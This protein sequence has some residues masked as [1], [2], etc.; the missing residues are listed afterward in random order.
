MWYRWSQKHQGELVEIENK[1]L[2]RERKKG[3]MFILMLETV[4]ARICGVRS[5][6]SFLERIQVSVSATWVS[7]VFFWLCSRGVWKQR[8]RIACSRERRISCC[9]HVCFVLF[10]DEGLTLL[11]KCLYCIFSLY[12]RECLE[13][14][15][16]LEAKSRRY[17]MAVVRVL[18]FD[19]ATSLLSCSMYL[20]H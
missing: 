20:P 14:L 8:L 6:P 12:W 10:W 9:S 17:W 16:S 7:N 4:R 5:L 1:L 3:F 2:E 11:W 13:S 18:D 19:W 15:L